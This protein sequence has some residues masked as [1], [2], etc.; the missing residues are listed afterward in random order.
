[1]GVGKVAASSKIITSRL[2]PSVIPSRSIWG[3]CYA[4]GNC[5]YTQDISVLNQSQTFEPKPHFE[6][7]YINLDKIK[8][9]CFRFARVRQQ[10]LFN[11]ANAWHCANCRL[12]NDLEHDLDSLVFHNAERTF[13]YIQPSAYCPTPGGA[14]SW[15]P[16]EKTCLYKCIMVQR[17]VLV[18]FGVDQDHHLNSETFSNIRSQSK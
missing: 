15:F 13:K 5:G 10:T 11:S 6:P 12:L 14:D 16:A 7:K 2:F 1:M 9:C 8:L 3:Y 17:S 4:W 18:S